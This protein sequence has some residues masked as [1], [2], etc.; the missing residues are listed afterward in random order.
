MSMA[1]MQDYKAAAEPKLAS[2]SRLKLVLLVAS[3]LDP[4]NK[5][6]GSGQAVTSEVQPAG[7]A[8]Q[9]FSQDTVDTKVLHGCQLE[10]TAPY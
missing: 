3:R 1:E 10:S 2:S 6:D 8:S 4:W 7:Q 5:A 9:H